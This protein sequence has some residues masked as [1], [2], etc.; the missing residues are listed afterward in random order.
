MSKNEM[1]AAHHTQIADL[2]QTLATM[3]FKK[4]RV[5]S[6]FPNYYQQLQQNY[7]QLLIHAKRSNV[8]PP[9]M[10]I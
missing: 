4:S 1:T 2:M 7:N 6:M 5:K 8:L 9:W 3:Q 10:T